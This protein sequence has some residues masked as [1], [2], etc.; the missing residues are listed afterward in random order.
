M[1]QS[2]TAAQRRTGA[3]KAAGETDFFPLIV[4]FSFVSQGSGRIV[5]LL[6]IGRGKNNA[7]ILK[8]ISKSCS[9]IQ[10]CRDSM[11]STFLCEDRVLSR[12]V[13]LQVRTSDKYKKEN[14]YADDEWERAAAENRRVR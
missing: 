11:K 4:K 8:V 13:T 1:G 3:N 6:H 14:K 2:Q 10:K 5:Q 7:R 12:E 9:P